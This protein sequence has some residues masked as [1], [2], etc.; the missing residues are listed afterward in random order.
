MRCAR[1]GVRFTF[2]LLG[3]TLAAS[4]LGGCGGHSLATAICGTGAH[5][6][7]GTC[8][9]DAVCGPG[10]T[11]VGST[12]VVAADAYVAADATTG[13][14]CGVGTHLDGETC[15]LDAVDGG[16]EVSCGIDTHLEG[17][18]CVSD[19]PDGGG[20]SCDAGTHLDG[21]TCVANATDANVETTCGPDAGLDG[22]PCAPAPD[23][24]A[25]QFI[26]RVGT[27]T[28]GADGYSSIP[29]VILGTDASGN[30]STATVVLDTSRAGAG[31]VSPATV[32]LTPTGATVYFTPCSASASMWCAGKVRITLALASAPTVVVAESQELTLVAPTGIG[33][34]SP[35]LV[36][37]NVIFYNGDA[38]DYIFSG[39]ET[40]TQGQWS[41]TS[42]STNVHVSVTPTDPSQGL[43]WDLYFDSSQLSMPLA[44]QVYTEAERWPFESPGH[45][46]LDVS[47]DGRG[48]NTVTGSFQI[49]DLTLT[50]GTLTSF[51]ATFEHHCE[52]GTPAVRGCVHYGM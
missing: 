17:S 40:I 1:S 28:I 31:I 48:C 45:P 9:V 37:G 49:E 44:P 41:A 46:G 24:G 22:E 38:G 42:S 13:V 39:M 25:A 12:C 10:T 50:S 35:C 2:V 32:T 23:G 29:V 6:E 21:G 19:H 47:G 34:D 43:W 8:V 18:V 51:T 14:S 36:G 3:A 26:V 33:S 4:A 27:T 30:P 7:K 11:L 15:V 20:V 52:G 5:Y 16:S